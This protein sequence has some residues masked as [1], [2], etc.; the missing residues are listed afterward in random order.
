MTKSRCWWGLADGFGWRLFYCWGWPA[1]GLFRA[2]RPKASS[3]LLLAETSPL[4][5]HAVHPIMDDKTFI[6][7][8]KRLGLTTMLERPM[9]VPARTPRDLNVVLIFQE[10]SYNKYLS[11]FDG[12]VDTQP[13]LSKYK[14]RM[15]LF[16]N[17]FSSFAG[18]MWARFATFTGLYPVP[19]YKAF[20]VNRGAGQKH[21]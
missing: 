2:T 18:S 7:T 5:S 6:A 16:P 13:L 12:K 20:T 10:S 19:D 21:V 15:E 17:F 1:V 9:V 4:F 8:A 14:S 11:L 3:A